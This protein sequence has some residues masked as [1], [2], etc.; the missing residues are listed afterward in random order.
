MKLK[1]LLLFCLFLSILTETTFVNF[2][3]VFVFS[4]L[5]FF[6]TQDV[7]MLF[8]IFLATFFLDSMRAGGTTGFI[9]LYTFLFLFLISYDIWVFNSGGWKFL[10]LFLIIATLLYGY[11]SGYPLNPLLYGVIFGGMMLARIIL[12]KSKYVI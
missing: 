2:P 9:S 8:V 10:F 1:L 6:F 11:I 5:L 7:V 4:V 12:H 3:F